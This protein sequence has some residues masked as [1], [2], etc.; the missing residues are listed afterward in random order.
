MIMD[1]LAAIQ[2]A[3]EPPHR[4]VLGDRVRKTDSIITKVMWRN[5]LGVALYQ[6]LV[7]VTL[8]FFAPFMF[9]KKYDY[10]NYPFYVVDPT[11]PNAMIASEKTQHYTLVFLTFILMQL[12]NS[13]NSRRLGV[14][15]FNVFEDYFSSF[16]HLIIL[17]IEFGATWLMV[18]FGGKIFRTTKITW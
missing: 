14:K 10:Y 9:N 16:W 13:F 7:M 18:L 2:L 5:I 17:A 8:I 12:F 11:D 6:F 1:T 3:T 4:D 15:D